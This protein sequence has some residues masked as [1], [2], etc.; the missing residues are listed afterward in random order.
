MPAGITCKDLTGG[1]SECSRTL[2]FFK[3]IFHA[4]KRRR[5]VPVYISFF[6]GYWAWISIPL[7]KL[8]SP[9]V[10]I[11]KLDGNPRRILNESNKALYN[12]IRWIENITILLYAKKVDIIGCE[13]TELKAAMQEKYA[14]HELRKKLH[15]IPN[16]LTD[17]FIDAC[18]AHYPRREIAGRKI[19]VLFLG[20][21]NE[22]FKG[23][24]VFLEAIP[25]V[26]NT[27]LDFTICGQSG[28]W[29]D[30]VLKDFFDKHPE[31]RHKTSVQGRVSGEARV[32][33]LL[34]ESDV[35][36]LTSFDTKVAVEGFPL[37]LIEAICSGV[38]FIASDTVPSVPDLVRDGFGENFKSAN[39]QDLA[40]KLD[41]LANHP[42]KLLNVRKN[43]LAVSQNLYAWDVISDRTFALITN[44]EG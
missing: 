36:C 10:S 17:D 37:V 5:S 12:P 28:E 6:W 13:S 23:L 32:A 29:S 38:Y 34:S 41:D 9:G 25:L 44:A 40:T 31:V 3:L 19:K 24:E 39:S 16:G 33:K 21:L 18:K 8:F 42:E 20:R 35:L 15:I 22:R 2:I 4:Y 27:N 14:L 11:N 26:A 30:R 43:G 1:K 7:F